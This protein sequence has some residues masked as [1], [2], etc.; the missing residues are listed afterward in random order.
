MEKKVLFDTIKPFEGDA[1]YKKKV[2]FI[3]IR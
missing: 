3:E 1:L 2:I